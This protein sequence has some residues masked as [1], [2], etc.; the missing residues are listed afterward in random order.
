V[1]KL[2]LLGRR[3]THLVVLAESH[4]PRNDNN[5][6][7][8]CRCDCG[9]ERIAKGYKLR[10]GLVK[11][12]G[13]RNGLGLVGLTRRNNEKPPG[14]VSWKNAKSRC[15]N[16]ED[17]DFRN[18]GARGISMCEEWRNSYASFFRDMGPR[19]PGLT[20]ERIDNDGPYSPGNC[21]WATHREQA[22]NRRPR[23]RRAPCVESPESVGSETL[24]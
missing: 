24:Q 6:R 20:L 21:R 11:S 19:P 2:N 22:A 16:P 17:K 8:V 9:E 1:R 18:Y 10:Q 4:E 13:C 12:C 7:W 23:K 5:A 14:Y 3:F 15:H